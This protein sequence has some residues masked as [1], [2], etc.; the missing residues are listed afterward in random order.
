MWIELL[1]IGALLVGFTYAISLFHLRNVF[2]Q[3][4]ET[5]L[6]EL[7]FTSVSVVVPFRDEEEHL[8]KI[9]NSLRRQNYPQHLLELIFVDDHSTDASADLLE[10]ELHTS[11]IKTKLLKLEGSFGKRA[12]LAKGFSEAE[13]ELLVCTDADC[14]HHPMWLHT[15]ASM[16]EN[17]APKMIAGP[18]A[19]VGLNNRIE[20][21]QNLEVL[22]LMGTAAASIAKNKPVLCSGANSAISKKAYEK[23]LPFRDLNPKLGDD[24]SL[25][26]A[27]HK[28]YPGEVQFVNSRKALVRTRL[29]ESL[30]D[31]WNQK[32][33]WAKQV[34]SIPSS[35][36]LY[37]G[38]LVALAILVSF[39]LIIFSFVDSSFLFIGLSCLAL[40]LVPDYM[41]VKSVEKQFLGDVSSSKY[42]WPHAIWYNFLSY[43]LLLF[44]W[45]LKPRW[46]GRK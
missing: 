7:V 3:M 44:S 10:R 12:A 6:N 32:A 4:P 39:S 15:L 35:F 5:K 17:H 18:I 19:G 42:F 14:V 30:P 40:K 25:L 41:M 31:Y 34:K 24:M 38:A 29:K 26:S 11:E 13:G 9:L 28:A 20:Q 1:N 45:M 16:Y 33:R 2:K 27:F 36:S 37:L 22:G 21:L 43:L 46:K 23:I 8:Q